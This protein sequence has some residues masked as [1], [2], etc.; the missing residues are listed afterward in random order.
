LVSP[1]IFPTCVNVV[2]GGSAQAILTVAAVEGQT[3]PGT[4]TITV[5]GTS[6]STSHSTT[7]TVVV[8]SDEI[9]MKVDSLDQ[10]SLT[11]NGGVETWTI[12]LRSHSKTTQLVQVSITGGTSSGTSPFS[13]LSGITTVA[14]GATV[15]I[16]VTHTFTSAD[17]GSRFR[18]TAMAQFGSSPTNLNLIS[19]NIKQGHFTIVA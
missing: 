19:A 6:G 17:L 9:L 2:A 16:T 7:V 11:T 5:T 4:Y 14:A 3:P 8:L 12:T 15:T 10:V 18:F 13:E 1:T